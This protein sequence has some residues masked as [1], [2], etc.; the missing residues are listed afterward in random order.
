M[1]HTTFEHICPLCD[2]HVPEMPNPDIW[3]DVISRHERHAHG[4]HP[5]PDHH[6]AVLAAIVAATLA[7]FGIVWAAAGI[8]AAALASMVVLLPGWFLHER[9][10]GV[11]TVR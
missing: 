10:Y 5:R 3:Q 11:R 8:P 1:S 6:T 4:I 7:T 2:L 9:H